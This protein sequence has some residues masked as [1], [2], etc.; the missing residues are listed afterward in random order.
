M[1]AGYVLGDAYFLYFRMIFV[2]KS[3]VFIVNLEEISLA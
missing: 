2:E 1:L 3:V